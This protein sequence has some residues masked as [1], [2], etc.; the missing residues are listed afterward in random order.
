MTVL[1]FNGGINCSDTCLITGY[2]NDG[3][4]LLGYN[5]FMYIEDDHKEEADET[6][7]FRKSDWHNGFFA[8]QQ[9][10]ILIIGDKGEK[11]CKDILFAE[12][13]KLIKRLIIEESIFP[14]QYNGLTAH[15]AFVN[16]LM[17]YV[18]G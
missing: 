16:A 9:G 1:T 3:Q 13:L 12:T 8:E 4:V 6:G 5:P 2:D 15:K 17:T 14:G 7:Y 18:M 11:P 10:S